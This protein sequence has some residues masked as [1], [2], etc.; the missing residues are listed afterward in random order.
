MHRHLILIFAAAVLSF[1]LAGCESKGD[2]AGAESSA[3][4]AAK[5]AETPETPAP[6]DPA[7]ASKAEPPAAPP[8]TP[9]VQ[10]PPATAAAP[11]PVPPAP[12]PVAGRPYYPFG[13]TGAT[14]I[15]RPVGEAFISL[16]NGKIDKSGGKPIP[17]VEGISN[18]Y[19]DRVAMPPGK[20]SVR[21]GSVSATTEA[22]IGFDAVAGNY[23]VQALV[24][25]QDGKPMWTPVVIRGDA[26]GPIVA[27]RGE[28][29]VG[30][31]T[32]KAIRLLGASAQNVEKVLSEVQE[33]QKDKLIERANAHFAAGRKLLRQKRFEEAL[34]EFATAIEIAPGFDSA[35]IFQGMALIRL[36]RPAEA[37]T[38]FDKAIEAAI[39]RRGAKS[40]WLA[41]P[42]YRKAMAL[43]ELGRVDEALAE[44]DDS[45]R[46]KPGVSALAAR[47][48]TYFVQGQLK[49][50]AGDQQAAR[51]YFLAAGA[52]VDRGISM[53][54]KNRQLWSMKSGV[55]FMLGETPQ[56]CEAARRA[57]ELGNC[58]IVE[59]FPECKK[60]GS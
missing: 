27:A 47:G 19:Y 34:K 20:V 48:N 28:V 38:S 39:K 30:L 16:V 52:D 35:H 15:L 59:D 13:E 21:V 18:G 45:I 17:V 5:T 24:Y 10:T 41:L 3:D 43:L 12:E 49:S 32:D 22:E 23:V 53:S 25:T 33:T 57:C 44:L 6:A 37:L 46:L 2:G 7:P 14:V 1:A 31:T 58:G 4:I 11:P 42:H 55:H 40:E 56:A 50:R 9:T 51:Q 29:I 26:S 36:N 8:T 60:G 54:G